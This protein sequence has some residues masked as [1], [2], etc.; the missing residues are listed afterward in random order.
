MV[1]RRGP[2]TDPCGTLYGRGTAVEYSPSTQTWRGMG[3]VDGYIQI[4]TYLK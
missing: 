3:Y 4:S 1:Y 2:S